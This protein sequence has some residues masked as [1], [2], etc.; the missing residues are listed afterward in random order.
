MNF[1]TLHL[2]NAYYAMK[3]EMVV[4]VEGLRKDVGSFFSLPIPGAIWEKTKQ[5][6]N[7]DFVAFVEQCRKG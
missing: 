3:D 5:F 7:R 2:S 4:K 6:Q 1:V